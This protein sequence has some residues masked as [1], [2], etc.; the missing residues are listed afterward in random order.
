VVIRHAGVNRDDAIRVPIGEITHQV[1]PPLTSRPAPAISSHERPQLDTKPPAGPVRFTM[2]RTSSCPSE[3][4]PRLDPTTTIGRS[5]SIRNLA[6]RSAHRPPRIHPPTTLSTQAKQVHELGAL[7][8]AS[9]KSIH[10]D[11]VKIAEFWTNVSLS[12]F[13]ELCGGGGRPIALKLFSVRGIKQHNL[14]GMVGVH[15][16][17]FSGTQ[18]CVR[19]RRRGSTARDRS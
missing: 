1:T 13:Y 4:P 11:S 12:A 19:A 10:H 9:C 8:A 3:V 17:R 16:G 14:S 5:S 6:Y 2:T 15:H 18:P 7:R